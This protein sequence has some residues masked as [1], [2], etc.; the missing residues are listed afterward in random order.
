MTMKNLVENASKNSLKNSLNN[1]VKSQMLKWESQGGEAVCREELRNESGECPLSQYFSAKFLQLIRSSPF[2]FTLVELLVVIAIIGVLIALLLPAVQAAREAARRMSC[3]SNLRQIGIGLQNYHDKV[4]CFPKGAK[5]GYDTEGNRNDG[6]CCWRII[7]FPYIEQTSIYDAIEWN[8][9][10]T[11]QS[12]NST[13]NK[14]TLTKTLVPVF[15]CPS[16]STDV[17]STEGTYNA[18]KFMLADYVGISGA[19]QD[20][21]NT[22]QNCRQ[23]LYG[24]MS[25]AGILVWNEWR[26]INQITDGTSNTFIVGEQSDFKIIM[27][28]KLYLSSFVFLM[29]LITCCIVIFTGCSKNDNTI[30]GTVSGTVKYKNQP[31][32]TGSIVF[33]HPITKIGGN[34]LLDSEGK[35]MVSKP[36]PVGEYNV[37]I[38]LPPPSAPHET[39]S[40]VSNPIPDKYRV[41]EQGILKFTV[42]KGTNVADFNLE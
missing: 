25:D 18:D 30:N 9:R 16:N 35:Y 22:S 12:S 1:S 20:P 21:V 34:A 38:L 27:T 28:K 36:I 7:L 13:I 15:R 29:F 19:Y 2:V 6:S 14:E 17:F 42:N 3:S 24:Y 40:V 11:G 39:T 5:V 31:V 32:T 8:K 37:A 26:G 4:N 33:L 41:P 23:F 10:I